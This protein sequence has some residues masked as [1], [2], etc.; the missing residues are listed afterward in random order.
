MKLLRF[1]LIGAAVF[2]A[3]VCIAIGVACTSGFQTWAVRRVLASQPGL[4]ASVGGVS[5]GFGRVTLK[6]LRCRTGGGVLSLPLVEMKLSLYWALRKDYRIESITAKNWTL[7]MTPSKSPV[8]SHKAGALN[9]GPSRGFSFLPSAC[10]AGVAAPAASAEV[11]TGLFP[12]IELPVSLSLGTA[13]LQGDIILPGAEGPVH[14]HA[15]L[16]GGN[17]KAGQTGKFSVLLLAA[18]PGAKPIDALQLR[19]ALNAT[20]DGPRSFGA[21]SML[22]DAEAKGP[23]LSHPALLRVNFSASRADKAEAYVIKIESGARTLVSVNARLPENSARIVGTWGLNMSDADLA[24]FALGW[25]SPHFSAEGNGI[26]ASDTAGLDQILTGRLNATCDNLAV[27]DSRLGSVGA[28]ALDSAFDITR[29]GDAIRLTRLQ[30]G[31]SGEKPVLSL[32]TLQGFEFNVKTRELKVA[33][34]DRDLASIELLGVPMSWT[35]GLFG[36]L[37]LSGGPLKGSLMLKA[38]EG[39]FALRS[40]QP[41]G[42]EGIGLAKAGKDWARDLSLSLKLGGDYAP[43]GW[44]ARIGELSLSHAG[45]SLFSLSGRAGQLAEGADKAIK[46]QGQWTSDLPGLLGQPLFDAFPAK[47]TQ[48][49][50]KGAFSASLAQR[51]ELQLSLEL[52]HLLAP[53]LQSELLP[54]TKLSLRADLSPDGLLTLDAPL[55]VSNPRLQRNSDLRFSG[56]VKLGAKALSVDAKVTSQFIALEDLKVLAAPFA[57]QEAGAPAEPEKPS[58]TPRPGQSILVPDAAPFWDGV[59]GKLGLNLKKVLLSE[60][61]SFSNVTGSISLAPRELRMEALTGEFDAGGSLSLNSSIRFTPSAEPY[62]LN[63]DLSVVDIDGNSLLGV[64]SFALAQPAVDARFNASGMVTGS[65]RSIS[66]M[67]ENCTG[68]F[69]VL[70]KGGHFRLL[71]TDINDL[72]SAKSGG[73]LGNIMSLGGLLGGK[74]GSNTK[75]TSK[76]DQ[77]MRMALDISEYCADI[78]FDQLS[79]LVTRDA[80]LDIHLQ[81]FALISPKLRLSGSGSIQHEEGKAIA[82]QALEL[83]L[84]V[85]SRDKFAEDLGKAG[86]LEA[87][88]DNLGYK[89]LKSPLRI[90]GTLA[91][92]DTSEF[93]AVLKK[94]ILAKGGDAFLD[95]ILGR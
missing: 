47:L 92:P 6:D 35:Q 26:F 76:L 79:V 45:H 90:G 20:L 24:P 28:L 56:T 62:S 71:R 72:L 16:N 19:G 4:D 22:L 55:V 65:G 1:F 86:L 91:D 82:D 36:D 69:N 38:Y 57:S 85:Y 42:A 11:F 51:K 74:S 27:I 46:I 40:T 25:T 64:S 8:R 49:S 93:K 41:L 83:R 34:P 17:L 10:A 43:Q 31:L 87:Q 30:V 12:L 13:E 78:P 60:R 84:Q 53:A 63:A 95:R 77:Y 15:N 54:E 66:A 48:G 89:G 73:G 14:I 81:D 68:K 32:Q 37:R 39:G 75:D 21:L 5:V 88:T 9:Q 80:K 44:Q 58:L 67:A 59:E 18:M 70:S 33:N 3:L 52:A 23:G 50:A 7:D 29:R 61:F 2:A 94:V